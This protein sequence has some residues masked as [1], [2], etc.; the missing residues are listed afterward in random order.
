[1]A[2]QSR[3]QKPETI[4]QAIKRG[5]TA[6][7]SAAIEWLE[8]RLF[9][10][11]RDMRA[12][13]GECRQGIHQTDA[14]LREFQFE[15]YFAAFQNRDMY[16]LDHCEFCSDDGG[17]TCPTHARLETG[18]SEVPIHGMKQGESSTLCEKAYNPRFDTTA[19]VAEITCKQC[20]FKVKQVESEIAKRYGMVNVTLKTLA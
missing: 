10:G 13:I 18:P 11:R 9:N 8:R 3:K 6:K 4:A 16:S 17:Y 14:A 2:K 20:A 12:M 5:L 1:M 15:I 7:E 19:V